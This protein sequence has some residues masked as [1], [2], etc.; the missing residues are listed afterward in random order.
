[1][2]TKARIWLAGSAMVAM[3]LGLY[4]A[5]PGSAGEGAEVKDAVL[6]IA[7]AIEKGDKSAAQSEAKALAKKIEEI[8][9]VMDL[10]K[11]RTKKGLGVGKKG[12]VQPDG[13]EAKLLAMERQAPGRA[14]A[15]KEAEGIE[16]MAYRIAAIAEIASHKPPKEKAKLWIGWAKELR[17]SAPE[18]AK[19]AKQKEPEALR[20]AA[21]KVNMAC[22]KCHAEFK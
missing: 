6:K 1:M 7:A 5:G 18:L 9:I 19:A 16:E 12:I 4:L 17:A 15:E 22:S 21:R 20:E 14:T 2:S 11:L 13:I 3:G 10:M 8:D